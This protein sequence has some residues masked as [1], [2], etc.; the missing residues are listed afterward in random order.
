MVTYQHND[1]LGNN[2][3]VGD[4]VAF[5]VSNSLQ[6]GVVTKLNKIMVGVKRLPAPKKAKSSNINKYPYDVV[7]LDG[8]LV[9]I[10][11]LKISA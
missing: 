3:S 9:S 8:A 10:Y 5:P 4:C 7:R 2:I 1:K 6:I 11:L